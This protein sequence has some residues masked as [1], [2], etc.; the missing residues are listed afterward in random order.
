[1]VTIGTPKTIPTL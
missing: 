1:M